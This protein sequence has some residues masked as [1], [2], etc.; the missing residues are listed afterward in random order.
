V[1]NLKAVK[2]RSGLSVIMKYIPPYLC[3]HKVKLTTE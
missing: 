2:L 1:A 3:W